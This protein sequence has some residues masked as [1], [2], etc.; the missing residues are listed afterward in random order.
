MRGRWHNQILVALL[1]SVST[2]RADPPPTGADMKVSLQTSEKLTLSCNYVGRTVSSYA[3]TVALLKGA[4]A[5]PN[6]ILT[7]ASGSG[8]KCSF[9]IAPTS[10]HNRQY[11]A[12]CVITDTAGDKVACDVLIVVRDTHYQ[13]E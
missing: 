1:L 10:R 5:A 8:S 13:P 3:V 11:Q 9:T 6:D 2:V 4:D 12:T 7:N